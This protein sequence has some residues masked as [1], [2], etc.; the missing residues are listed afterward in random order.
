MKLVHYKKIPASVKASV[1]SVGNFDGL[2]RGHELLVAEVVSRAKAGA[3]ASIIVTFEPHTRSV[4]A[5]GS[6]QTVLSTL[7]EKSVLMERL[8]LDYLAWIPFDREFAE[9][10][11]LEFV[12]TV[13]SER[14]HAREWVMGEHHT[15]GKGH[16]G[17]KNLLQ[18]TVDKN[19][20]TIFPLPTFSLHDAVVSSTE[21]RKKI[22]GGRL[23]QAV[24]LLGH[25]YLVAVR[26]I[27]G[28]HRG[29]RLGF[30][31]LNFSR[32]S[33]N[34]VLPPPG[35]FAAELGHKERKWQGAFYFG[36]CPTFQGRDFHCEFHEFGYTD[37]VPAEGEKAWVWLHA[38]V[39]KDRMFA[40][41]KE[42]VAQMEKDVTIIK[43]FFAGEG[44]CP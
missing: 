42:L 44:L 39:R 10:P 40:N 1:V 23:E 37:E 24:R 22:M 30:P 41:Q 18:S 13:L 35:V 4:V 6:G 28:A 12:R 7:E 9:L 3:M 2:H 14:L 26:R 38:M 5:P 29:S 8:G 11:W 33:V 31:T 25:P 15:F 27:R 17:N 19:H 32:P 21:I 16:G 20:I 34:K 43:H 36:N